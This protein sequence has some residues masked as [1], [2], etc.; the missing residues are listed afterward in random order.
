MKRWNYQIKTWPPHHSTAEMGM[1]GC[2]MTLCPLWTRSCPPLFAGKIRG[3]PVSCVTV[4]SRPVSTSS[5][6]PGCGCC[7]VRSSVVHWTQSP[8]R[9]RAWLGVLPPTLSSSQDAQLYLHLSRLVVVDKRRNEAVFLWQK[10]HKHWTAPWAALALAAWWIL[11]HQSTFA[12]EKKFGSGIVQLGKKWEQTILGFLS[13][14]EHLWPPVKLQFSSRRMAS[15]FSANTLWQLYRRNYVFG[16]DIS[17]YKYTFV[18]DTLIKLP[19]PSHF[20]IHTYSI[21]FVLQIMC[22]GITYSNFSK[23]EGSFFQS[24]L[25]SGVVCVSVYM[26]YTEQEHGCMCSQADITANNWCDNVWR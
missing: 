19:S 5:E 25:S 11:I 1:S 22:C 13:V 23:E 18:N 10:Q 16:M 9:P 6:I 12:A 15:C 14:H 8:C 20:Q 21:A 4:S 2:H 7:H 3:F 24:T 26:S 17:K